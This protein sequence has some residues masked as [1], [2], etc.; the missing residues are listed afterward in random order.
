MNAVTHDFTR[1]R[2]LNPDWQ[3]RLSGW[4]RQAFALAEK[5]WPKQLPAK[6]EA[7]LLDIDVAYAGKKLAAMTDEELAFRIPGG[8]G[9]IPTLWTTPRSTLLHLVGVM[10]GDSG[11]AVADRELTPV[12]ESLAEYFLAQHWLPFV[13]EAWPGAEPLAWDLQRRELHPRNTRLF[14]ATEVL[15]EVR[16]QLRGAWGAS[17]G[18]WLIQQAGLLATFDDLGNATKEPIAEPVLSARR[19]TIVSSLPVA[20]A[21]VVGCVNL[22]LSELAKLRAGDVVLLDQRQEDGII[23][24]AGGRDLFRA[25]PGR[26]GISKA[27]QIESIHES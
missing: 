11:A 13:R 18:A 15:V 17:E 21:A 24:R 4:F 5:A 2:R 3:H 22:K 27:I 12:E 14:S 10:L 8:E 20:I 23:A 6:L 16:W 7:S 19:D 25:R 9:R 26:L 1:P